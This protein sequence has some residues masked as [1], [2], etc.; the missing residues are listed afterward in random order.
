M[1]VAF[2]APFSAG[3]IFYASAVK[4]TSGFTEY[5]PKIVAYKRKTI[6][7]V[8]LLFVLF[9]SLA[10]FGCFG[11]QEIVSVICVSL[12]ILLL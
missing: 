12:I 7:W 8:A 9:G 5:L 10:L 3:L 6:L 11:W 4:I 2:I 1:I